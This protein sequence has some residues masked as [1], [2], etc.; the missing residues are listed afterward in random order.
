MVQNLSPIF[1]YLLNYWLSNN[2]PDTADYVENFIGI[3]MKPDN[4]I[5]PHNKFK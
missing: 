5:R 3:S 2:N 4:T 1:Y